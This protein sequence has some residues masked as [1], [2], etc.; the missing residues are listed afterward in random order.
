MR[1]VRVAAALVGLAGCSSTASSSEAARRL[2]LKRFDGHERASGR[3]RGKPVVVNFFSSTCI[4]CQT[5]MPAL[6]HVHQ[7][8]GDKVTFLGMDVQDTVDGGTA[9]VK[10]VGITWEIG[11]D[12]DASVL[13]GVVRG[14]GLPTTIVLDGDG[15]IVFTRLGA[16]RR[17]R[18][19]ATVARP[20][21]H[22]VIDV[23]FAL[24]FTTG[25]VATVNPCGFAMLPAYLSFFV[26]IE[27]AA[28]RAPAGV[29]G[30][31][32]CGLVVTLGFAA[33]FAVSA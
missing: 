3:I 15:K 33:T 10:T 9:F 26:G 21:P 20:P 27:D 29:G 32:S 11:R 25:M 13:Q 23:D 19:H 28:R 8:L 16:A 6:E 30:R 12:P 1:R 5:E 2:D 18:S 4:P 31:S 7:T 24:A 17:R 22:Q 14:T